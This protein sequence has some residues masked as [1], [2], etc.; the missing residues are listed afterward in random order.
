MAEEVTVE[1][2][3][4]VAKVTIMRADKFNS[5]N[6]PFMK[7]LSDTLRDLDADDSVSVIIL[8]GDGNH[9]GAGYDLKYEWGKH[10][11]RGPMGTRKMLKDCADFEF[12]PWDCSKPV[13]AMVRG[14]CLAGSCELA[15]MCCITYA[16][17]EA[18]F[19][20]PEIRF[21]TAPPAVIMPWIIGLKRT[22]ELL[23]TGDMIT[24]EEARQFGMVNKVFP[25]DKLEEETMKYAK[26]A[27]AIA[28]EGLQ[29]TKA[30]INQ[31][32][33]I[34]GLRSAITYGVEVGGIL[35]AQETEQYKQFEA[36]RRE[37]GLSAAIRWRESQFD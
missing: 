34:A 26:R 3:D 15:M 36:V 22:R 10:Y 19:G 28:L 29:T 16:S 9:F 20:E 27:S 5:M 13:I 11:G 21:S 25:A 14:Y 1:R 32:A 33:E 8:T 6:P 2:T 35:D 12:G 17:E 37:K 30:A 4:K 18:M 7:E 23:Y 31:G 24:A